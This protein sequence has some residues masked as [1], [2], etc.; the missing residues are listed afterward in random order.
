MTTDGSTPDQGAATT[1]AVDTYVPNPQSR[2]AAKRYAE[3]L[4]GSPDGVLALRTIRDHDAAPASAGNRYGT[5]DQLHDALCD[6][7]DLG[8]GIFATVQETDGRGAKTE[9]IKAARALFVDD[10]HGVIDPAALAVPPSF[11][12]R[13]SPGKKHLYWLLVPGEPV[14]AVGPALKAIAAKLGGDRNVCDI[15]RVLRV[16]GYFHGKNPERTHLVT[17]EAA[18]PSLRYRT[19]DVLAGL[20]ATKEEAPPLTVPAA[21]ADEPRPVSRVLSAATLSG[22]SPVARATAYIATIPGTAEGGRNGQAYKVACRLVRDFALPDADALAVL[23]G[24]NQRNSPPLPHAELEA[25]VR[26]AGGYATGT[27]GAKLNEAPP[28]GVRPHAITTPTATALQAVAKA[29]A[30]ELADGWHTFTLTDLLTAPEPKPMLWEAAIPAGDVGSLIAPGGVGK[31]S[32]LTGLAIHRLVGRPFLGRAVMEG[33][34]VV[35]STEDRAADYKAKIAQWCLHLGLNPQAVASRIHLVDAHGTGFRLVTGMGNSFTTSPDVASLI[36]LIKTRAPRANHVVIETVS[37]MGGDESNPAMS[38]IISAAERVA[39]ETGCAI[40]LVHHTSKAAAR[41]GSMDEFGSRGGGALSDNGRYTIRLASWPT[42]KRSAAE[43]SRLLGFEPSEGMRDALLILTVPKINAARKWKPTVLE[44]VEGQWALTFRVYSGTDRAAEDR[45][46]AT[47][48]RRHET[49]RRL[50]SLVER[51]TS[52]GIKATKAKLRGEYRE[53]TGLTR[54][55]ISGALMNAVDDGFLAIAGTA[56]GGDVYIPGP[57]QVPAAPALPSPLVTTKADPNRTK[58]QAVDDDGH[59]FPIG[60][61]HDLGGVDAP[62]QG[63]WS[64]KVVANA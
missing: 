41:D 28:L 63:S 35:L 7:N 27:A 34:T 38:A 8:G 31:T 4:T 50:G 12:V 56:K 15:A 47:R 37:R 64:G 10:D 9:N 51:L 32:L 62:I 42:D 55:A 3:L 2:D 49:G 54:D 52:M 33:E 57:R 39:R 22:A 1:A 61:R 60:R 14:T 16:P 6:D 48:V 20:G 40:T 24:W 26:S 30:D 17:I 18:D 13:T 23:A 44:K 11:I 19:A 25:V 46:G 58:E 21:P 59:L 43:M 45:E 29:V 53:G 5:I 36:D